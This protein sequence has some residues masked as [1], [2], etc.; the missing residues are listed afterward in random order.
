[1]DGVSKEVLALV[2][3]VEW[4]KLRSKRESVSVLAQLLC[5]VRGV[6]WKPICDIYQL[7]GWSLGK[8]EGAQAVALVYL[9]QSPIAFMKLK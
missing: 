1:M 7:Q 6:S 2:P 8:I 3:G 5:L 9:L 4:L